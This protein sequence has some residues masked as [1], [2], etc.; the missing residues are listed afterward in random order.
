MFTYW[1][2]KLERDGVLTALVI[3]ELVVS[4]QALII[5]MWRL[6]KVYMKKKSATK[7]ALKGVDVK[8]NG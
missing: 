7:D 8:T 3:V 5:L 2:I 4:Y 6:Y 1:I